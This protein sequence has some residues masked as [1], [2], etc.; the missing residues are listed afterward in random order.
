MDKPTVFFSHASADKDYILELQKCIEERTAGTVNIFQSS[1]GQSISFGNNW[2]YEI[3]KNLENAKI[4]FV[5]VSPK[6]LLSSWIYFESGF[7][8]SKGV[9]VIPIG[10]KGVDIGKLAP[11]LNLMQGFNFTS[12]DGM[13]NIIS[14]L[15]KE[16]SCTFNATFSSDDFKKLLI[17]DENVKSA[18]ADV[19]DLVDSINFYFPCN[20]P[21]KGASNQIK[22]DAIE[23]IR[24]KF[25][26]LNIESNISARNQLTAHGLVSDLDRSVPGY[27]KLTIDP[28]MLHAYENFVNDLPTFIYDR[29]VIGKNFCHIIFINQVKCE[30]TNFK[31][32]AR[33]QNENVRLSEILADYYQLGGLNFTLEPKITRRVNNRIIWDEN[34]RVLYDFGNFKFTEIIDL[35]STLKRTCVIRPIA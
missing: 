1:D 20:L 29:E 17:F 8:Y 32:S 26:T 24:E 14:I 25:S 31:V 18:H 21:T 30:T 6:S 27:L 15:N 13:V 11:P 4:M 3:E 19:L 12:E 34:I 2:V 10:I 5:F 28:Y 35:L 7:S 23:L 9:K 22:A 16:F 33:L